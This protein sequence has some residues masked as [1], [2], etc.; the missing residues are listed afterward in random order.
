LGE[1]VSPA[2]SLAKTEIGEFEMSGFEEDVVRFDVAVQDEVLAEG[3][4][5]DD[6][7]SEYYQ[8]LPLGQ[9]VALSDEGFESAPLAVLIDEVDVVIGLDHLHE[10]DHVEVG[11]EQTQRVDLVAGELG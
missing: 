5:G 10:L 1:I 9:A 8:G 2:E 6:E 7:L 4:H 3:S 11:L